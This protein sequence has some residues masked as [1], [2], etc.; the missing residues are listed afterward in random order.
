MKT[1]FIEASDATSFN[2]GKFMVGVLEPEE[3]R[4]LS[5][6]AKEYA[7]KVAKDPKAD[8]H[9]KT[10]NALMATRPLLY[11]IGFDPGAVFVFDL[12]TCEGAFF[13]PHGGKKEKGQGQMA[14]TFDLEKHDL[15]VCP[16]FEPFL[17]WLYQQNLAD[18]TKLP[19]LVNVG[20]VPTAMAGYRRDGSGRAK[21]GKRGK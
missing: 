8:E 3:F 2:W 18:I 21:K 15:W 19:P 20:H 6:M 13:S 14:A 5:A 12:Q 7:E 16:M 4:R 17:G 11:Q 10:L 1:V 9:D